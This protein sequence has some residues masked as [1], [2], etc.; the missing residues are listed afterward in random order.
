M[1]RSELPALKAQLTVERRALRQIVAE[2]GSLVTSIGARAPNRIE[3]MAAAG[4]LHN[5]YN[6]IENCLVRVA[7]GIDESLPTGADWHRVLADQLSVPIEGLRPALI[8]DR[9]LATRLAECR[10]F[11]HAFRHMYFFDLD[12]AHLRPLLEGAAAL[13]ADFEA[14]LDRLLATV[15]PRE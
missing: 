1:T 2:I 7:Q 14:A 13:S 3:L 11:R 10:R 8:D 9:N 5:L 4:Y 12:W 15:S 6:A